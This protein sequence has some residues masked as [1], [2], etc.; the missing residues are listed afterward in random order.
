MAWTLRRP[1]KTG[2][3]MLTPALLP[4]LTAGA[5][6]VNREDSG[7]TFTLNGAVFGTLSSTQAT[8]V[9]IANVIPVGFRSSRWIPFRTT[10]I[11]GA[12]RDIRTHNGGDIQIF[13]L[14]PGDVLNG[15]V[16]WFTGQAM[17]GGA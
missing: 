13:G 1:R 12:Q 4:A 5:I 15:H 9:T 14:Q 8:P 16:F 6:A 2:E 11:Y 3:I 10:G 7:V 17:P